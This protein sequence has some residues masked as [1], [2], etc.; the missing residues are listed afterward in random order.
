MG[1][2]ENP[3]LLEVKDLVVQARTSDRIVQS[4]VNAISFELREGEVLGVIGESGAGKSTLALACMGYARPGAVIARGSVL[5]R[6]TNLLTLSEPELRNLRGAQIAYIAQSAAASFNPAKRL[7]W[8]ATEVALRHGVFGPRDA[9]DRIIDLYRRLQLPSP[10]TIGKRYPHQVSGGQLQRVMAAMA[11]SCRPGLLILDEPTTALDV[12]TQIEVL[13]TFRDL[14]RQSRTAALY[15]SHDL[16]VVAQMA[17]RIMVLRKGNLVEFGTVRQILQEPR[18]P[19]TQTLVSTKKAAPREGE[20]SRRPRQALLDVRGISAAYGDGIRVLEGINLTVARGETTAIVGESGSGKS[21]LA[22]VITGLR[23][24]TTGSIIFDQQTLSA[25]LADRKREERRRLQIIYQSPDVALNP[26]HRV[27]KL[28][29]RPISFYFGASTAER[30]RRVAELLEQVELPG[31]YIDRFP[32]QL[33]GGEKQRI[34][35]ARALAAKPDLILCDEVTSAL[36]QIVAAGVLKLLARLQRDMG[37]TLILITHDLSIARNLA[38]RTVVM[39]QGQIV[40]EGE[41]DQFFVREG[42]H[43]YTQ[44][45]LASVPEMRAGWLDEMSRRPI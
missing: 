35:I 8:Q 12:T 17:D 38:D 28:L 16:A 33:S 36:D 40:E 9:Y 3:P 32:A 10:E 19:Y 15:V 39:W 25:R 31:H 44:R 7:D 34:C 5:F 24:P 11:M 18:E 2:S 27:G 4:L 30:D 45:L 13:I 42:G 1:N 23:K 41:T 37:L 29:G 21:T 43:A 20:V 14:I 26:Q 6:G 22:R